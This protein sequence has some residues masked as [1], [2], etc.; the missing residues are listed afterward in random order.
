ML[1]RLIAAHAS[2]E[3]TC[4]CVIGSRRGGTFQCNFSA[5]Q[6]SREATEWSDKVGLCLSGVWGPVGLQTNGLTK[7]R[8][9][10]NQN[11]C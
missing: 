1:R 7:V 10:I 3:R 5:E 11:T 6:V 8:P 2:A 9:D 4:Y